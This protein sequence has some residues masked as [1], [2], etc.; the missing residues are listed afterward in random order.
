MADFNLGVKKVLNVEKGYSNHK[1][2]SGGETMWGITIA[3]AREHGYKGAM[4]EMPLSVALMIYKKAYWDVLELDLIKSQVVAEIVFDISVNAGQERAAIFLQKAV[5]L[6]TR[7]NI[8]PDGDIGNI[9][10]GR[11]NELMGPNLEKA[12]RIISALATTHYIKCCEIA[13]KNEDFLFGW[14]R[15]GQGYIER[16]S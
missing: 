11:V 10:I 3:V 9:T 2:D 4:K 15:R 13:E 7:N 14:L 16:L 5:N 1:S 8:E 6:M 12:V